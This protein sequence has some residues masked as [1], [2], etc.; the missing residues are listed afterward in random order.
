MRGDYVATFAVEILTMVAGLLL[1]HLVA[2]RA[3]AGSFAYYQVAR[4]L[5]STLQPVAMIGLVVGL[6]RYLP[7]AGPSA[8][9]LS[10]KAFLV[11]LAVVAVVGA[12]GYAAAGH[13]GRL[14]GIPGGDR[15]VQVVFAA[16]GGICLLAISIAALR[17]TGQVTPAN[18]TTL[19]GLGIVPVVAFVLVERVDLFLALQGVVMAT[20]AVWGLR[21][22]ARPSETGEVQASPP[23]LTTVV[24]YGFRRLPGDIAL[25]ALYAFP[26]FFVAGAVPGG[27]EAGYIGFTTSAITL[28]CSV[29]GTLTPVLL[30]RL[31]RHLSGPT[32][33]PG[34]WARLRAMPL[35]A[36]V[37]AAAAT[38]FLALLA[39]VIVRGYLG[40]E[41]GDAVPVLR[42]GLLSAIALAAFYAARPALDALQ[43]RPVTV[44]LLV[45]SLVV[46]VLVTYAA[47]RVLEPM[48]AGVLGLG[49]AA[50][51]L[52]GL[53]YVA[54]LRA[55]VRSGVTAGVARAG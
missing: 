39:P 48:S 35:V 22:A 38:A 7:R 31:S 51:M 20:L 1:F 54:L 29:F 23:T 10:R 40:A 42:L 49:V 26:T 45:L 14:L 17:G 13:L 4:G 32:V 24:G 6:Q 27:P 33:T 28:V 30:P 50:T 43:D 2:T 47:A 5:I 9:A 34:L 44:K 8:G 41:F 3:G 15:P 25:P 52:G 16:L 18:A 36:V 55:S 19:V 11:Q 46:E 12:V 37:L 21:L 53:S